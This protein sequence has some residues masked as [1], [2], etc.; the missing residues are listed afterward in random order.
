MPSAQLYVALGI[1]QEEEPNN[2]GTHM[3]TH[4][5]ATHTHTLLYRRCHTHA[6]ILYR[7][8]RTHVQLGGSF[9]RSF[10]SEGTGPT[11]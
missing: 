6:H 3:H 7:R 10:G 8:V 1:L 5:R 4:T 9:V 2:L 11:S